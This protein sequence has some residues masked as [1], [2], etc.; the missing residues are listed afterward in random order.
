MS[1]T[2]R[3]SHVLGLDEKGEL[4]SNILVPSEEGSYLYAYAFADKA[5]VIAVGSDDGQ[6]SLFDVKDTK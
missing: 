4:L 2:T 3:H 6:L 1:A 5:Q